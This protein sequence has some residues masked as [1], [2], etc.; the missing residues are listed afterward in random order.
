M[1]SHFQ[2]VIMKKKIKSIPW[3]Q[4]TR[5]ERNSKYIRIKSKIDK[6]NKIGR[7]FHTHHYL[8][9]KDGEDYEPQ[10]HWWIDLYFMSK[11]N[12]LF[13]NVTLI[14]KNMAAMD[15]IDE[16]CLEQYP[17]LPSP[18]PKKCKDFNC[19][20]NSPEQDAWGDAVKEVE[21]RVVDNVVKNCTVTV[22]DDIRLDYSYVSGI[23]LYATL[24]VDSLS[25]ENINAWIE[26]FWADGETIS[27]GKEII[28]PSADIKKWYD[29]GQ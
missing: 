17:P 11:K 20:F 18:W 9:E 25:E 10:D 5:K 6:A 23:G 3:F 4:Q 26:K 8:N 7:L 22:K 24:D 15:A 28:I 27:P 1:V 21:K 29:R 16:L 14:T 13:Y 2:R 12:R 19:W